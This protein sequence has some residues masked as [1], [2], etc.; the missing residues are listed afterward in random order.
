MAICFS[1]RPGDPESF[2][3]VET[4]NR[5][6]FA[7]SGTRFLITSMFMASPVIPGRGSRRWARFGERRGPLQGRAF[8]SRSGGAQ[9]LLALL[10][11]ARAELVGLQRIEDAQDLVDVTADVHVGDHREADDVVRVDDE[12]RALG[13][14]FF[15]VEDAERG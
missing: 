8:A 2:R 9:R 14:A 13:H 5:M 15:V 1:F 7:K 12:G 10:P 4:F 3:T 11:I 6:S